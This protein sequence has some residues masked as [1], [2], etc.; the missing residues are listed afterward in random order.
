MKQQ[1]TR[2]L[3]GLSA[4]Q[5]EAYELHLEGL[6][7]SD[8]AQRMGIGN[9]RAYE[10]IARARKKLKPPKDAAETAEGSEPSTPQSV[11]RS[12]MIRLLGEKT[13][14]ILSSMDGETIKKAHLRDKAVAYGVLLDKQR[15]LQGEPTEIMSMQHR[16]KLDEL[17][18][19]V[20]QEAKR[21][22]IQVGPNG[23]PIPQKYAEPEA[24][25]RH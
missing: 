16:A 24:E 12:E 6:I 10:L 5:R 17:V 14:E 22:G 15:L 11:T 3:E 23:M 19:I 4:R 8:I 21:R 20:M 2:G 18:G 7:V 1:H 13:F 9:S 25:T